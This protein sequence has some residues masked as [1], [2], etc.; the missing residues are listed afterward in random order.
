MA[1]NLNI[2]GDIPPE[3]YTP[4]QCMFFEAFSTLISMGIGSEIIIN[5]PVPVAG[6]NMWINYT[7][8]P[9]A[10]KLL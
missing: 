10:A 3:I 1:H 8:Y 5:F 2:E 9:T 7:A 4:I 6:L